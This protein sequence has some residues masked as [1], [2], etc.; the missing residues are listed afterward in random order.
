VSGSLSLL[1]IGNSRCCVCVCCVAWPYALLM[2]CPCVH[3]HI[4]N[5]SQNTKFSHVYTLS[6][7]SLSLLVTTTATATLDPTATKP[8]HAA[9]GCTACRR[10]LRS[11]PH[12]C[13]RV[14]RREAYER[15]PPRRGA[16]RRCPGAPLGCSVASL[17]ASLYIYIYIYMYIYIFTYTQPS[18]KRL[19]CAA[20]SCLLYPQRGYATF[21]VACSRLSRLHIGNGTYE[22]LPAAPVVIRRPTPHPLRL[23]LDSVRVLRLSAIWLIHTPLHLVLDSVLDLDRLDKL[24]LLQQICNKTKNTQKNNLRF[25]VGRVGRHRHTIQ[26][27][28]NKGRKSVKQRLR[29]V[30]VDPIHT[31]ARTHAHTHT[32]TYIYIYICIYIYIVWAKARVVCARCKVIRAQSGAA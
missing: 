14:P 2:P 18:I 4:K 25:R 3:T 30:K 9:V 12:R 28:L 29:G 22:A 10:R 8:P 21:S 31:Q 1:N 32:H 24:S 20:A 6:R 19:H 13:R 27:R 7:V 15:V 16:L 23:I 26:G 5:I 11:T 17:I